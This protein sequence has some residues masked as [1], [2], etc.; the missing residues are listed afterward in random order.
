M[1][2][3]NGEHYQDVINEWGTTTDI[4]AV[5]F[6]EM[7]EDYTDMAVEFDILEEEFERLLDNESEDY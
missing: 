4:T 3:Y 1:R 6:W 5:L 2:S 7:Y